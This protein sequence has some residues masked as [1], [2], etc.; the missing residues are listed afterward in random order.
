MS[1][2]AVVVT[3][4]YVLLNRYVGSQHRLYE[5]VEKCSSHRPES[6]VIRL[7]DF[8][9][10]E[11]YPTKRGWLQLLYNMMQ[12]HFLEET[13][14]MVRKRALEVMMVVYKSNRQ[15]YEEEILKEVSKTLTRFCLKR[16][17]KKV[18]VYHSF[19]VPLGFS[20]LG[21]S[22]QITRNLGRPI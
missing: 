3:S 22:N 13:R 2:T 4:L 17:D 14:V 9:S 8:R 1:S 20:N 6:S 5:V 19:P 12:K 15:I 21:F 7:I 18:T 10:N 11:I 16:P